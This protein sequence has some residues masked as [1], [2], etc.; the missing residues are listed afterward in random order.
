MRNYLTIWLFLVL[1]NMATAQQ[2]ALLDSLE[3]ILVSPA[4]DSIRVSVLNKLAAQYMR[5]D[6][7][8]A[9][10]KLAQSKALTTTYSSLRWADEMSFF[11][12]QVNTQLTWGNYTFRR[13]NYPESLNYYFET[14]KTSEKA[15]DALSKGKAMLGIGSSYYYLNDPDNA[16]N[17]FRQAEPI[18]EKLQFTTGLLSV[19]GNIA[20]ILDS[21]N[22]KFE[23]NEVFK[24]VGE[25]A[26]SL[27]LWEIA[28]G[29][30]QNAM[31][32]YLD[33]NDLD[34]AAVYADRA[35]KALEQANDR[36]SYG[37][38][39]TK[40]SNI[41][42]KKKEFAQLRHL[43]QQVLDIG[44]QLNNNLLIRSGY[45]NL[46]SGYVGEAAITA[47]PI[48]KDSFYVRAFAL[49]E[50]GATFTDSIFNAEKAHAVAEMQ[51]KYETEKKEREISQLNETAKNNQIAALQR[52][53][54]LRQQKIN[55]ENARQQA[56]LLEKTNENI[57][58]ELAVKEARFQEQ[59]A[60]AEQNKKDIEL[61]QLKSSQQTTAANNERQLRYGLLLGLLALA[62]ISFLLYRN[63]LQ[64]VQA[65]RKMEQHRAEIAAKNAGLEAANNYKSIFL[66]NMSHE[67]RTPL[68]TII[69]MS[70]LLQETDLNPRQREFAS[71]VNHASKNLLSVINEIL[72]FSKIEAGKIELRPEVFDLHVLL[73][74]Q[75]Q[76][77]QLQAAQKGI[78]LQLRTSAEL[79]QFV[80]ADPARLRQ[81]LLNLLSNAVKFT[82]KGAVTLFAEVEDKT[83]A[84]NAVLKF[85]VKDSGVGISPDQLTTV[86]QPFVQAG[87]DTH[88]RHSG[89]GLGLAI[90]KQ[91]VELQGGRIEVRSNPG[92]G[93]EFAFT[94]PVAIS[95]HPPET[96]ETPTFTRTPSLDILL[97][98]D[99]QFNQM[100]AIELLEKLIETPRIQIA[101]NGQ[102]AT[103]L[104][105]RKRFDLIF[106]D[107][108]MPVMDG[109][110]ATKAIRAAGNTTPVIALTANATPEEREKC[111]SVGMDDYLSKP[112]SLVLLEEKIRHWSQQ[113]S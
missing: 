94:L 60:L 87:D 20:A 9:G 7:A 65:Q 64:R 34:Q 59:N 77:L 76:L 81:V 44:T 80:V 103:E 83:D 72:D 8:K 85:T 104:V 24:Q 105:S 12:H 54:E 112:I 2:Q 19:K 55:A 4:P 63:I 91:L 31:N 25:I 40:I 56:V 58:L 102:E 97:V 82:E 30:W 50:A 68:N 41:H 17:Y 15:G 47:D 33:T 29:A 23:A 3:R 70:D 43:S 111:L 108:K 100:L 96:K 32:Y 93:S 90:A 39:L 38:L 46:A 109:F 113:P 74:Q 16:L 5:F 98:E 22:Q 107:V 51:I 35:L 11:R 14:I 27:G 28:G 92:E 21:R 13:G 45:I 1:S 48:L 106:M 95:S 52:E 75:T 36:M 79:P 88:L 78:A 18:F 84:E 61:L 101:G 42:Y 37:L 99:N 10:E 69:G 6:M 26:T 89:T 86:F 71:V 110:A 49:L 66:S 73:D 53:I 62:L 57:Q 67:I